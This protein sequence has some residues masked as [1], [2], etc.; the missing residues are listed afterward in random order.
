MKKNDDEMEEGES[1][2]STRP[3]LKISKKSYKEPTRKGK[4]KRKATQYVFVNLTSSFNVVSSK[5]T[6]FM[7]DMNSHRS[8]IASVLYTTQ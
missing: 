1:V 6:D 7:P 2:Q 4:G 3:T 5:L 8:N